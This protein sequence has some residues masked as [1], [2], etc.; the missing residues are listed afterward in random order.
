MIRTGGFSEDN[1]HKNWAKLIKNNHLETLRNSTD[2]VRTGEE[3]IFKRLLLNQERIMMP[4]L[5]FLPKVTAQL[6]R[7]LVAEKGKPSWLEHNRFHNSYNQIF[8]QKLPNV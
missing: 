3:V 1:N 8:N 2:Q 5:I 6:Q 7:A 4:V